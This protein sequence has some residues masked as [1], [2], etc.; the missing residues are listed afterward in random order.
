MDGPVPGRRE[1]ELIGL[2]LVLLVD[3]E[4]Y[5]T[6]FLNDVNDVEDDI[7]IPHDDLPQSDS[8]SDSD[9]ESA[10]DNKQREDM[11]RFGW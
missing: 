6:I 7:A 3:L 5:L 10:I 8:E 4:T 1:N 2:E 11:D 9:V